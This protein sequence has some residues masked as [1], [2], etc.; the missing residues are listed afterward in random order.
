MPAAVDSVFDLAFWISDR[1]LNDNEYMQP[2]K[3]Q[4]LLYLSQSYY[5]VAYNGKKLV[6]AIFVAEEIGPIEPAVHRAWTRGRP[7]FEGDFNL[8]EDVQT[9]VDSVW[10][11]FG[12]HSA[13]HLSKICKRTPAYRAALKRGLRA[14]I[15]LDEMREDFTKAHDTPDVNQVVKPK[16]ARSHKGRAVAVKAWAPR[17]LGGKK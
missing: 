4:Y 15:Y 8:D 17:V 5:A 14:E 3:L 10:R 13:E 7:N 6:P 9:F 12:H 1:A 11:R 16:V 2:V